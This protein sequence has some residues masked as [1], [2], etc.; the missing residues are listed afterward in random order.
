MFFWEDG[1]VIPTPAVYNFGGKRAER[2]RSAEPGAISGSEMRGIRSR[3]FLR[4]V[5]FQ[6]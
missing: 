5:V 4:A 6:S 1:R 2:L 3:F